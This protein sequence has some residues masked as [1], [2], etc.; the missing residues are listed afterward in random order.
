[1][2]PVICGRQKRSCRRDLGPPWAPHFCGGG[3]SLRRGVSGNVDQ[4]SLDAVQDFPY[5]GA[6]V[7]AQDFD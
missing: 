2:L 5:E 1:M 3:G 4:V 6:H 7:L